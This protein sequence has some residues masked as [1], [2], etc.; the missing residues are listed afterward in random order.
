MRE[1]GIHFKNEIVP[2]VDCPFEPM[3]VSSPQALFALAFFQKNSVVKF[4]LQ[5]TN[6]ISRSIRRT[7]INYEHVKILLQVINS[8]KNGFNI[9]LLVVGRYYYK[10]FQSQVRIF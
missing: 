2:P 4:S 6:D 10:F 7:V 3:N 5:T 9:F 1:V 8:L